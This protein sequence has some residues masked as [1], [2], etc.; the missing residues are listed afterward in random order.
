MAN[1]VIS[2]GLNL[3]NTAYNGAGGIVLSGDAVKGGYFVTDTIANIP[4]WSNVEGTLCFCTGTEENPINKFY[5]YNGAS[6]EEATAVAKVDD[7]NPGRDGF[8]TAEDKAAL[9]NILVEIGAAEDS[10]DKGTIYGRISGVKSTIGAEDDEAD[11]GTVYGSINDIRET[12]GEADDVDTNTVYGKINELSNTLSGE[13]Q[14]KEVK[15]F[16]E[17]LKILGKY[18]K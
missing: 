18:F 1:N 5:K 13:V 12:I 2:T 10:A 7:E 16:N 17:E 14:S 8:M 3:M 4:T 15:E 11:A 9:D 6:W